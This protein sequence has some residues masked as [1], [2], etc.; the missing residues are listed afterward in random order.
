MKD[1][2]FTHN[3]RRLQ[4]LFAVFV[5][6]AAAALL[7]LSGCRASFT[8]FIDPNTGE[9][10]NLIPTDGFDS[11]NWAADRSES[12]YMTSIDSAPAET[13]ALNTTGLPDG[14]SAD[15]IRRLEIPNLFRNGDFEE[16]TVGA[17]PDGWTPSGAV[18]VPANFKV[19]DSGGI[20]N[21]SLFFNFTDNTWRGDF[22]L[23]NTTYGLKD[24]FLNN[25]S[26]IIRFE[27]KSQQA[28]AFDF[29][30]GSTSLILDPSSPWSFSP[31]S[32]GG[33]RSF[34]DV[35]HNPIVIPL[36]SGSHYFSIGSFLDPSVQD[37]YFDNIRVV[38]TDIEQYITVLV[39]RTR[40]EETA[41]TDEEGDPLE[42]IDG[43]YTFSVYIKNDPTNTKLRDAGDGTTNRMPA[44][45]V[46]L[47]S[48]LVELD[49]ALEEK[50]ALRVDSTVHKPDDEEADWSGWYQITHTF[51]MQWNPP[52]W[53]GGAQR[54]ELGI[55]PTD[56][57]SGLT[58]D[59]GSILIASPGLQLDI[60]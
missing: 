35:T 14:T 60:P 6:T 16:S 48:R 58:R 38:R 44:T 47:R 43:S 23:R 59:A 10:K 55:T 49:D 20:N 7:V 36:Q 1:I 33:L 18:P 22:D 42:L 50:T 40:D 4:L 53:T 34:P 25:S 15:A 13:A 9:A 5:L 2:I 26:Y 31:F 54:L 30:D 12:Y 39:E 29:H 56:T 32:S 21:K 11:G 41:L 27:F 37:G 52:N 17:A 28:C 3:K 24:G 45:A 57:S 19:V 46:T 8:D 51:H